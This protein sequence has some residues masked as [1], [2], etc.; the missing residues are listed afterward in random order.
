MFVLFCPLTREFVDAVVPQDPL[1]FIYW[2][3]KINPTATIE[4]LED[5]ITMAKEVQRVF[6]S[7]NT[8][9]R[10]V[11]VLQ[12]GAN[13]LPNYNAPAYELKAVRPMPMN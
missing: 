3:R 13:N 11:Q 9:H 8:Y 2:D 4:N 10:P 1:P 5:A 6:V 12:L 7:E